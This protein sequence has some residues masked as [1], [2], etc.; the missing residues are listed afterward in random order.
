[1]HVL[2]SVDTGRK[3]KPIHKLLPVREQDKDFPLAWIR[4]EG[5]GR[6]FCSGM[7][8]VPDMFWNA[9]L[10]AHFL[11]GIQFALGDLKADAA[12]SAATGSAN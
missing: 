11:A 12:P 2:L 10:L 1:M 6:V 8:H 3:A 9:P 7:G 4:M 5:K